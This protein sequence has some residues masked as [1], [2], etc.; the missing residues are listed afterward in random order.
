MFDNATCVH[1]RHHAADMEQPYVRILFTAPSVCPEAV[2][3]LDASAAMEAA[4]KSAETTPRDARK[5]ILRYNL[6]AYMGS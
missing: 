6:R 1:D 3:K 5:P 4:I 2:I